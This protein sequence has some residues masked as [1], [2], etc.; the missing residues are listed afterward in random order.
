MQKYPFSS[1]QSPLSFLG[2]RDGF[3]LVSESPEHLSKHRVLGLTLRVSDLVGLEWGL[4]ICIYNKFPGD[5]LCCCS[6]D[7]SLRTP[8]LVIQLHQMI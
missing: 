1:I 6:R 4:R 3:D 8:G 7:H 2:L 5:G